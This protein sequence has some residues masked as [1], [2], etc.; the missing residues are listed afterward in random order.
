MSFIRYISH[1]LKETEGMTKTSLKKAAWEK[2]P[3]EI[4]LDAGM[5]EKLFSEEK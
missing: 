2:L 5:L 4:P 1:G 3:L